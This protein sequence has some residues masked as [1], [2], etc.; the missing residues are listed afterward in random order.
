[1]GQRIW[2]LILFAL[3]LAAGHQAQAFDFGEMIGIR[4]SPP[5]PPVEFC[6]DVKNCGIAGAAGPQGATGPSGPPGPSGS[7]GPTGAAGPVGSCISGECT[8]QNVYFL[9]AVLSAQCGTLTSG[10]ISGGYSS[11]PVPNT[12]NFS[13]FAPPACS[14]GDLRMGI[15]GFP[16]GSTT[17]CN[18]V[19]NEPSNAWVSTPASC[20]IKIVSTCARTSSAP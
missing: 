1:M 7:A 16:V 18:I 19:S 15:I 9:S 2:F 10:P 20:Q 8:E 4:P 5:R 11:A 17:P 14:S 3:I 13:E 6:K 12:C